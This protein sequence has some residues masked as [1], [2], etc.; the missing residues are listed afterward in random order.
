MA[1]RNAL[2]RR[3]YTQRR[4]GFW[5]RQFWRDFSRA[6][7][8]LTCWRTVPACGAV[9]C[10]YGA[11]NLGVAPWV[12]FCNCF[13]QGSTC[14]ILTEK[15]PK[16]KNFMTT[17]NEGE[18]AWPY[19]LDNYKELGWLSPNINK[20]RLCRKEAHSDV[21]RPI[22]FIF[23]WIYKKIYLHLKKS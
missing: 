22:F 12:H 1:R 5:C 6:T 7:A 20:Q 21:C 17:T 11:K 23:L 14:I 10:T 18:G 15:G 4:H 3:T 8:E 9:L 16:C 2:W 19:G 13:P